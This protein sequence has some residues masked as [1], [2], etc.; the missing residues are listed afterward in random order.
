MRGREWEVENERY[1]IRERDV[2]IKKY[3]ERPNQNIE[4]EIK[5]E[6]IERAKVDKKKE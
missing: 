4:G 1:R 3:K 2:D 6:G 5:K